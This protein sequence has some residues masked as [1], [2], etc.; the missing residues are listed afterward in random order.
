MAETRKAN[1]GTTLPALSRRK[2]A[3]GGDGRRVWA[4]GR[5]QAGLGNVG[6]LTSVKRYLFVFFRKTRMQRLTLDDSIFAVFV[7]LK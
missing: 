1:I 6:T 3:R 5:S 4:W 2:R 7:S